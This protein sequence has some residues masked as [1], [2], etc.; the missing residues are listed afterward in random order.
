MAYNKKKNTFSCDAPDKIEPIFVRWFYTEKWL[1]S[2]LRKP[3]GN[4]DN[5]A[6]FMLH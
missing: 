4:F 1:K 6:F 3:L 2:N 5:S